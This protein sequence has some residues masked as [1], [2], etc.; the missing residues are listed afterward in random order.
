LLGC[1][2]EAPGTFSFHG[3]KAE[4][5]GERDSVS[6]H[7]KKFDLGADFAVD[8]FKQ[9]LTLGAIRDR[10]FGQ[11][12]RTSGERKP[13]QHSNKPAL[14]HCKKRTLAI[15]NTDA[16]GARV[17]LSFLRFGDSP[18]HGLSH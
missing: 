3:H 13:L 1:G 4:S 2:G 15:R 11:D 16:R 7:A 8:G 6:P 18:S 14:I 9:D 10:S 5:L 12:G 17:P